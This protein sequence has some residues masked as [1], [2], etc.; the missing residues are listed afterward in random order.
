M[1]YE[2]PPRLK[3]GD[4]FGQLL[5]AGDVVDVSADR[6]ASNAAGYK[7][8]IAAGA[9]TAL[10]KLLVPLVLLFAIGVPA[11]LYLTR[12]E[13]ST[14][15]VSVAPPEQALSGEAAEMHAIATASERIVAAPVEIEKPIA[16]PV[17]GTPIVAEL[18]QPPAVPP[19]SELPEQIRIYEE[20]RDAG[21]RGEFSTATAAI[22]D[23]LRRF[24]A[25]PLRA[26]AELTRAEL[27]ARADR[28]D[29]AVLAVDALVA[30]ESH[31]GRRGE[32]LRM[33]GDLYRRKG[34]CTRALDAYTRALGQRL[35]DRDRKEVVNGQKRCSAK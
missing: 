10:W 6:L 20:A 7:T 21:R 23:L 16:T 22:D 32:L 5:R 9:S 1:T 12:D 11:I 17:K 18:A 4:E 8:L 26:E 33:L 3:H 29:E 2:S 24:P 27:F 25:T 35:S 30:D 19:P 14:P 34:D 28:L 13:A 15:V 31:R